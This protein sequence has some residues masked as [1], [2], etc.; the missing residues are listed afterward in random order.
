MNPIKR[1]RYFGGQLLSVEDFQVEQD[2]FLT[3]ERQRNLAAH[4]P[5]VLSGLRVTRGSGSLNVTPGLAIDALGREIVVADSQAVPFPTFEGKASLVVR[6]VE[7]MTDPVPFADDL[8]PTRIEEGFRLECVP[9]QTAGSGNA[10]V[11]A[12]LRMRDG[13]WEVVSRSRNVWILAAAILLGAALSQRC[14]GIGARL[15]IAA[16]ALAGMQ[17]GAFSAPVVEATSPSGKLQFGFDHDRSNSTLLFRKAGHENWEVLFY[18]QHELSVGLP[19]PSTDDRLLAISAGGASYGEYLVL[20]LRKR[21]GGYR[22]LKVDL[23]D[24]AWAK[25]AGSRTEMKGGSPLHCYCKLLRVTSKPLAVIFRMS[26][27]Y[28]PAVGGVQQR[29][30]PGIFRYRLD[31]HSME[32]IP[33]P[34]VR[35]PG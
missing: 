2:Y 28:S 3:K 19:M 22:E 25:L 9:A 1:V 13:K 14:L 26:G 23:S 33:E 5:G 34:K 12:K 17:I 32:S 7:T 20:L 27:D 15:S 4:G 31:R 16:L 6:Y 29:F 35:E 11:L 10:I 24:L 30:E 21:D 18:E 8:E